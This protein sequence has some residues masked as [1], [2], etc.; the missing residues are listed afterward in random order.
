MEIL[1][2]CAYEDGIDDDEEEEE[3]EPEGRVEEEPVVD[4]AL[5]VDEVDEPLGP[6][7]DGA[8]LRDGEDGE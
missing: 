1:R 5:A 2:D 6:E 3:E 8:G 4:G 7:L